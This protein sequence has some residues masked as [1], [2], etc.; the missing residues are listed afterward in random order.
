MRREHGRLWVDRERERRIADQRA[1]MAVAGGGEVSLN[2]LAATERERRLADAGRAAARDL[3]HAPADGG[4][5]RDAARR[6][7]HD[8]AAVDRDRAGR[9]EYDLQRARPIELGAARQAAGHHQFG[10]GRAHYRAARGPAA[11]DHLRAAARHD[12]AARDAAREHI[13]KTGKP[14]PGPGRDARSEERR[15]GKE[16]RTR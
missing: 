12:R 4:A 13:L 16:W 10:A 14:D 1:A 3:Q 5:A 7:D 9:A 15:V 11:V 6:D 8:A 2:V